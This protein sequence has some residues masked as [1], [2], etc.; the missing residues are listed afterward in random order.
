MLFGFCFHLLL[1]QDMRVFGKALKGKA[2]NE[3]SVAISTTGFFYL[4]CTCVPLPICLQV[5]NG[6]L[7]SVWIFSMHKNHLDTCNHRHSRMLLRSRMLVLGK[8]GWHHGQSCLLVSG[9][10]KFLSKNNVHTCCVFLREGACLI[11]GTDGLL[12]VVVRFTGADEY[13]TLSHILTEYKNLPQLFSPHS[14][15]LICL[16]DL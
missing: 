9:F 8:A 1:M 16:I 12:W 11:C 15:L 10:L 2:R 4:G 3:G 14:S 5:K 13:E 7:S 6:Y